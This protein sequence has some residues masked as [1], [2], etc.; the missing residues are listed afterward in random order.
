MHVT[1]TTLPSF[2]M[3]C[4]L[5]AGI[6]TEEPSAVALFDFEAENDGE[7]SFKEGDSIRLMNRL[8]EN[9]L[10]GEVDG[11]QG[12]FPVNCTSHFDLLGQHFGEGDGR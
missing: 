8:D 3:L 6:N 5:R 11:V 4:S 7:L 1:H 2:S 10:E 9:W 12:M